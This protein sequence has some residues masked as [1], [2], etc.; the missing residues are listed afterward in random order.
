MKISTAAQKAGGITEL[1]VILGCTRSAVHKW[2]KRDNDVE[3][4]Q[5]WLDALKYRRPEWFKKGIK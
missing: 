1:S 3:V 5:P 4:P 2:I